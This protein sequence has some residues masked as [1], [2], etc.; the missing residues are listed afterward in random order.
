VGSVT[1]SFLPS[2]YLMLVGLRPKTR[3]TTLPRGRIEQI[4]G[5]RI[6]RYC[7]ELASSLG[8]VTSRACMEEIVD[9]LRCE[10]VRYRRPR[11]EECIRLAPRRRSRLPGIPVCQRRSHDDRQK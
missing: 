7:A 6:R 8:G 4:L 10:T 5:L 3:S 11:C 9:L 1:Q 2:S